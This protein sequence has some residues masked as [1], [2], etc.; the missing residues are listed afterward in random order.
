MIKNKKEKS[1]G[2]IP[3]FKDSDNNLFFCLIQH[4][5][6]HFGFPKGHR[7]IGESEEKTAR[8]ELK[9]ETG[10]EIISLLNNQFFLE[11]YSFKKDGLLHNKTVKYFIGLVP[12]TV[13]RTQKN[14]K[15]EI[16]ELKWVNYEEAKQLITFPQAREVLNQS[17]NFL[18][19]YNHE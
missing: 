1:F 14:F 7:D 3:V 6:G 10:I 19:Q 8:R 5:Q 16:P 13:A 15:D 17:Y 9:E 11:K 4:K 12:S 2:I 18:I